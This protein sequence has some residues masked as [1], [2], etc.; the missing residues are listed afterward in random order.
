MFN[1]SKETDNLFKL[2]K[3]IDTSNKECIDNPLQAVFDLAKI[4]TFLEELY[5]KGY[6]EGYKEGE[7]VKQMKNN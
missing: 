4:G 2:L 3:E 1:I 5:K 6:E 7:K